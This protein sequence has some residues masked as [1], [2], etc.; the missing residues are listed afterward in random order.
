[1]FQSIEIYVNKIIVFLS[2][3]YRFVS[4]IYH[5]SIKPGFLNILTLCRNYSIH[6]DLGCV[7]LGAT[8]YKKGYLVSLYPLNECHFWSLQLKIIF[9]KLRAVN[10]K[11]YSHWKNSWKGPLICFYF[12]TFFIHFTNFIFYM[13]TDLDYCYYYYCIIITV[14]IVSFIVVTV[15]NISFFMLSTFIVLAFII[16]FNVLY[17]SNICKF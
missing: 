9:P 7:F 6:L 16:L 13:N 3:T 15:I 12:L 2:N 1:M 8:F 5:I 11:Q 4:Y 14:V 17:K 10:W